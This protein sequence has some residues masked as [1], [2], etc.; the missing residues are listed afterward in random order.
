MA[1]D[2]PSS[3]TN[4][5]S[6]TENGITYTYDSTYGVW[7]VNPIP[8]PDVFSVA[9]AAFGNANSTLV[10]ASAAFNAA[11]NVNLAPPFNVANAGFTVANA[12]FTVA[13]AGVTVAN[14]AFNK[15]NTSGAINKGI[16][17]NLTSSSTM[18][19]DLANG[20]CINITVS[21]N[22][23]N[24]S[25]SNVST[26]QMVI[27]TLFN[28]TSEDYTIS[29]NTSANVRFSENLSTTY[30]NSNYVLV[31]ND[32]GK[33]WYITGANRSIITF[34][35]YL[36]LWGYNASGQLGDN[37]ITH[38][39]SPVQT[40]SGGTNW[41]LVGGGGYRHT[42]AIKTD[43]TLWLWGHNQFG[44]LGDNTQTH[45]SSP[46]QTVSGGTNW[47]QVAGGG[48][49]TA[50]IKT[51]GTLWTWGWND[52]GQLGDNSIT[53]KSSPVQTVS[54]GTNWKQVSGGYLH[55]A[56]IKTDGTL[57]TWGRNYYYGSLG[58]NTRTDR[59]SPVQTVSGGT[60]WKLVAGGG[61]HTAAIKTDGTLWLWGYNNNGQL[62]DNSI[63][64]TS[65][66]I[67]TV[68]AGT[69]WKQVS[70]GYLNTAAIKTDGTLWTWGFNAQGQLGDN[71]PDWRSSPVQTVSGGTNWKQVAGGGY[72][73]AAIKTDGT[74]WLWG[75]NGVGELGDNTRTNRSSPV[76]T[77]SAG[78]NWKQV[79]GG[80]SGHTAAIKTD[81][82]LWLWGL[83]GII[84]GDGQLGDNS[85]THRSSPVQTVSGGTN[86]KQVA[87]GDYHTAAIR[88]QW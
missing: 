59:S 47:K 21:D 8:V 7:K 48:Y 73:T 23:N 25:F 43:G 60:N 76:Q 85:I 13:N 55:T 63:T 39:S 42:A 20:D 9:N 33:N 50:A 5:Q 2:F 30:G 61:Y 88:D 53:N 79:A 74:L 71:T 46:V 18:S 1:F 15:A 34:E 24:L 84:G 35:D 22:V 70:C 14:A 82:T 75:T 27:M 87:V 86:W 78:T 51:D 37:S 69:N 28:D 36:W 58:N 17:Q 16:S 41:K 4:G 32:S 83:N 72:I 54:G 12:G 44:A 68:S 62:G 81:G 45:R 40:V 38:R 11:N 31:T 19:I 29:P 66:P 26:N 57:W 65:S 3:P 80:G 67:Q 49:H 6:H 77:V 64:G 52:F 10:V 56:A